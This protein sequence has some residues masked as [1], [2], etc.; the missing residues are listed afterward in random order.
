M[1]RQIRL[2][3]GLLFVLAGVVLSGCAPEQVLGS[4]TLPPDVPD[5]A[6]A[7]TPEGA[8]AAYRGAVDLFRQAFGGRG[9]NSE[10]LGVILPMALLT[11]ELED[12]HVGLPGI[13]YDMMPLDARQLPEYSDPGLEGSPL[14]VYAYGV[15]Q[16]TRGQIQ[17]ALGALA[18]YAP[19][20]S[21]AL[22]GRL[23]ALEGY[24]EI[25]L[26]DLFCSG[27]P[28]STL[29]FERDYTYAAGSTTHEVYARAVAHFDSALALASD[30]ADVM[31][32]AGVGKARA[33]LALGDYADAGAAVAEVPDEFRYSV[34]Y[35]SVFNSF[36]A[37]RVVG[38]SNAAAIG[39]NATMA[40][41]EG[42]N[43]LPYLSSQDPR[44]RGVLVG[45]N[46]HGVAMYRPAKYASDGS[47]PIVLADGIEA[48][49]IE[50]EAQLHA[51]DPR[52]LAT[53]NALRTDGTYDTRPNAQDSTKTD[54]LWHA[55][56]G[57][58]AGLRPLSDPG[59]PDGRVDLVFAE[60]GY[61]L[62][63]TGHR[64]GDLRRLVREYG[65][66]PEQVYPTGV[67]LGL[68][69]RYGTDVTAPIPATERLFNPKFAGCLNR[70]A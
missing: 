47:S 17:E 36:V 45:T 55:G 16:E 67:Y 12:S 59:T 8:L 34:A 57:G 48:Q 10:N 13:T 37:W 29:D 33:L 41:R 26:A 32:L 40:D 50:A 4:N 2:M 31:N 54:T 27:V 18:A 68:N 61:W 35:G 15:L 5:P 21:P 3:S 25:F 53:L 65:R 7:K 42:G 70:G 63:L 56:T 44:T 20:A 49:L 22:R 9:V 11:D 43:G 52:W 62:Y 64:Q 6:V 19:N 69:G 38:G 66:N 24:T 51:N 23:Y 58:V 39:D 1:Q 60:R 46:D 28:L 14:Y 30:S